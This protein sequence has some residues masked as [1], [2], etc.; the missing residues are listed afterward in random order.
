MTNLEVLK[1]N[2]NHKEY[3]SDNEYAN[4]LEMNGLDEFEEYSRANDEKEMLE[5][6]YTVLSYLANDIDNL[7]KVETEFVTTSA[8][9]QYLENRMKQIRNEIE[10]LE[11]LE[12]SDGSSS[13]TGYL[14]FNS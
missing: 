14:F 4:I 3:F 13:V 2:L 8:A 1:L 9:Q 10:R 11:E 5:S 6:V 12:K 7:R